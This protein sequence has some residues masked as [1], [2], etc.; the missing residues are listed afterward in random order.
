MSAK[1]LSH[2]AMTF[3]IAPERVLPD[4]LHIYDELIPLRLTEFALRLSYCVS[5]ADFRLR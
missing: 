1:S 3:C 2:I 4:N 5:D